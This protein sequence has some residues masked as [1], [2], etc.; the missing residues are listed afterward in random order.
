MSYS[1]TKAY[2]SCMVARG[3]EQKVDQKSLFRC[4]HI[5]RHYGTEDRVSKQI[6]TPV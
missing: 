4:V 6:F 3:S 1:E 2:G 5:Y